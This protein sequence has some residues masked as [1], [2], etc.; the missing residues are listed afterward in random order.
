MKV[1]ISYCTDDDRKRR[2]L[3]NA[4]QAAV[5]PLQPVVVAA[6]REPG[7]PLADKV[8]D[9]I[10][11]SDLLVPILTRSSIGNQW[12]NQEIGY[13]HGIGR[14]VVPLVESGILHD[15]KGFIHGQHDLPFT[16]RG[17]SAQPRREANSFRKAYKLLIQDLQ[18]KRDR[19]FQ[20]SITPSRIRRGDAYTTHVTYRGTI[21]NGFFDNYVEHLESDFYVWNW[22][23]GTL[24]SHDG[25]PP[26]AVR[27][28]TLNGSVE[29][30][31]SYS[32]VTRKWPPGRYRILVRLYS[33][34]VPGESGRSVVAENVHYIEV[35]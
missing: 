30:S 17:D 27:S 5:P 1:F 15:L 4:F 21:L 13:A 16:F 32:H 11:E 31:T 23:P 2:A 14:E 33:H 8:T 10:R 18:A 25:D 28:G 35:Y 6:R 9:C 34:P 20:S 12:V 26:L 29:I 19:L 22:D 24:P 7:K 3:S